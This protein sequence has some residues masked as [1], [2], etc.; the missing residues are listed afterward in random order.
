MNLAQRMETFVK[1]VSELEDKEEAV[2][3]GFMLGF[4]TAK[5]ENVWSEIVKLLKD[6]KVK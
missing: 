5:G 2:L 6:K 3:K 4:Q 1:N